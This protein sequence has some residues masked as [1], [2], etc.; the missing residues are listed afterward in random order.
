MPGR[1]AD[2]GASFIQ[3]ARRKQLVECAIEVIAEVG[4]ARASTVRIARRAGVSRGVLTYHF[5][6]RAELVEQVVQ[7]VYDLGAE[8]LALPM[9]RAGDPRQA[10][11]AFIAG[12]IELYAAQPVAMAALTEI[13]A[14][15]RAADGVSRA[16]HR[17]HGREMSEMAAMLRAG[18]SQGL[19]R[20]FD[21]DVMCSTIRSALDGALAHILGGG[22]AEPYTTELQAIF[23]AATAAEVTR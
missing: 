10:L 3:A 15:A 18:Q 21:V 11:L 7:S 17:R 4:L 19:F 12:S 23:D 20:D 2:E 1:T 8:A 22:R 6:D 16:R 9:A 5:R 13:Y 14:D